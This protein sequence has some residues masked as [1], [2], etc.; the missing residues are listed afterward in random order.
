MYQ[1]WVENE[2]PVIKVCRTARQTGEPMSEVL[3]EQ[4]GITARYFETEHE[5]VLAFE[6]EDRTAVVAQNTTGYAMVTVRT[7]RAG[8]EHERY[9]GFDMALDHAAE[10]LEVP[11]Q[12]LPVPEAAADMGM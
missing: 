12:D 6:Y 1:C 10:L 11:P 4:Q 7:T 3:L 5:R 9:Y 8:S 2:T